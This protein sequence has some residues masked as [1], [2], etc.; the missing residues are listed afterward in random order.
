MQED[1]GRVFKSKADLTRDELANLFQTFAER[2]RAGRLTLSQG[3]QEVELAL[4][5]GFRVELELEDEAKRD[6]R[7]RE[8]EIEIKWT[9][10]DTGQPAEDQAPGSGF[11]VS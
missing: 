6:R 3:A 9:V 11:T 10:D 5:N 7:V 2:I 4:P 8:L 1:P